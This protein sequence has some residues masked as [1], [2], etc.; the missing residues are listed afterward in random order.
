[1][2]GTTLAWSFAFS[3]PAGKGGRHDRTDDHRPH[4]VELQVESTQLRACSGCRPEPVRRRVAL[5]SDY[6][7]PSRRGRH[8]VQTVSVLGG[9]LHAS[10]LT[11]I[12]RCN[13]MNDI[14]AASLPGHGHGDQVAKK[15][16]MS[17]LASFFVLAYGISW[18]L[19]AP[20]WLP[21]LGVDRLPVLPFHHALGGHD[22]RRHS[23]SARRSPV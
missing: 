9:E 7:R 6:G 12:G 21:A 3:L 23:K 2:A 8:S 1:M 10:K 16:T 20:L 18:M 4:G 14:A 5:R 17:P 15:R 19:W 22:E 11:D 13:S